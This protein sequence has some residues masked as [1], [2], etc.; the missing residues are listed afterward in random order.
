MSARVA[1]VAPVRCLR[2]CGRLYSVCPV[3][4]FLYHTREVPASCCSHSSMCRLM[5]WKHVMQLAGR[6]NCAENVVQAQ[7]SWAHAE[8]A[9]PLPLMWPLIVQHTCHAAAANAQTGS[10]G[11]GRHQVIDAGDPRVLRGEVV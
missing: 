8:E 7:P 10:C 3:R 6:N 5:V 11:R 1:A 4:V 2:S 9:A